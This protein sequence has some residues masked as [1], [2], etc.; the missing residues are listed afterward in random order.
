MGPAERQAARQRGLDQP[1]DRQW[2]PRWGGAACAVAGCMP[3]LAALFGGAAA[4]AGSQGMGMMASSM[5]GGMTAGTAGWVTALGNLSWPLLIVSVALL[6]W[7]FAR[8][9]ARARA[10]AY[11]GVG[12]LVVNQL[13]MTPWLFLPALALLAIAFAL[14]KIGRRSAAPATA[15]AR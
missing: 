10:V 7:S 12:L 15:G 11:A 2:L 6:V 4:A 14:A 5:G 8:T 9:A 1:V 13:A 3:M